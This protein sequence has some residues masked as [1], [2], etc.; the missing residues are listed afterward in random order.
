[1]FSIYASESDIQSALEDEGRADLVRRSVVGS[2]ELR[3]VKG[4]TEGGLDARAESLSVAEGEDTGVVDLCL[5]EC[6]LVKVARITM[7]GRSE[8]KEQQESLTSWCQPQARRHQQ[9]WW[10]CT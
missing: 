10:C 8:N 7:S 3:G 5:D 1:M 4:K 2:V 9:A 6:S